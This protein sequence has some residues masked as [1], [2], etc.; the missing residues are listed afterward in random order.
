MFN[1]YLIILF[2]IM[3]TFNNLLHNFGYKLDRNFGIDFS[4]YFLLM[5]MVAP[6]KHVE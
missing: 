2:I 3:I 4:S 5:M 6:S 1:Y